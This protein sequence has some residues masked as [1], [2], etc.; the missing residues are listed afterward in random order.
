MVIKCIMIVTDTRHVKCHTRV[1][2]CTMPNPP[3][4]IVPTNIV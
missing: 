1:S 3:T 4:N 2:G